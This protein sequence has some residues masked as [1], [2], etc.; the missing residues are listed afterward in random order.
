[1]RKQSILRTLALAT[2]LAAPFTHAALADTSEQQAMHQ[3]S[4]SDA[5]PASSNGS[6]PYDTYN[7]PFGD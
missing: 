2:V 5:D 6:G 4:T 3:T 7:P 1:M